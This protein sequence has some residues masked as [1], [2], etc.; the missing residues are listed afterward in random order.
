MTCCNE[1]LP[2]RRWASIQPGHCA[3]HSDRPVADRGSLGN[4]LAVAVEIHV[5]GGAQRRLFA[6]VEEVRLTVGQAQHHEA[7]T[8]EIACVGVDDSQGEAGGDCGVDRVSSRLQ[9][10]QSCITGVMMD[11][12]HH[13]VLRLDGRDIG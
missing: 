13:G 5:G 3:R 2:K 9:H 8:A 1:S 11:A 10:L 12:D 4:D 6:E 7:A